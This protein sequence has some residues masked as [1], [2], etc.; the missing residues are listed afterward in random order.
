MG[1]VLG[2]STS[3]IPVSA[4]VIV[5]VPH[6]AVEALHGGANGPEGACSRRSPTSSARPA[7]GALRPRPLA[8]GEPRDPAFEALHAAFKG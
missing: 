5:T 1:N 6:L 4:T 3:G 2:R 8:R 7:R